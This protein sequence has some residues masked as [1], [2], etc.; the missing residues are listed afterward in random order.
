MQAK[1]VAAIE[2]VQATTSRTSY[3]MNKGTIPTDGVGSAR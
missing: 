2:Q 3:H 1:K